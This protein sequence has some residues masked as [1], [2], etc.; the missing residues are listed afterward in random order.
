MHFHTILHSL[1]SHKRPSVL[2]KCNTCN[3]VHPV[4]LELAQ[5]NSGMTGSAGSE[6]VLVSAWASSCMLKFDKETHSLS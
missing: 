1:V 6:P 2:D 4:Q 5:I 3:I